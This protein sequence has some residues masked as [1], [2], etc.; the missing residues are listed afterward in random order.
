MPWIQ[1]KLQST[2][3]NSARIEDTLLTLGAVSVTLEDSADQPLFEPPPGATPLWNDVTYTGLF[4]ADADMDLAAT[5]LRNIL[6]EDTPIRIEALEDKDWEREWM[7]D[8]K[9]IPF[10]QRLWVCP[11][12]LTPPDPNAI[13]MLLDPGL[14][15]GTGTHPTTAMCLQ[16]LDEH[17]VSGKT[18]MDFGCGSGILAI[19]A[20]LLGASKVICIDN[21]P[22]ALLATR[23]NAARNQVEDKLIVFTPE[24]LPADTQVDIMLANILAGPL[25][26]LS[27][28]LAG[29]THH[30][31]DIVLSGI[32]A[33]QAHSVRDAYV[34]AGCTM[35]PPTQSGDWIRLHGTRY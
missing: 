14:A 21:D 15:F 18:V 34:T 25:I 29:H 17:D 22:Q 27:G 19:A 2:G 35:D 13:N 32:L 12:W 16:W 5:T 26:Q 4:D 3:S 1:V 20:A 6:G 33:E 31:G 30:G 24:Q 11:S 7:K 9:P 23:E 28:K 10:G 8:Y